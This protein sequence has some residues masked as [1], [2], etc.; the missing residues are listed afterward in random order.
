MH[1]V[2]I[3]ERDI[4]RVYF[5]GTYQE[6]W[7]ENYTLSIDYS[8]RK[9]VE[10]EFSAGLW[11]AVGGDE[12]LRE[13]LDSRDCPELTWQYFQAAATVWA[14]RRDCHR[15]GL[16]MDRLGEFFFSR[17]N[18]LVAPELMRAMMDEEGWSV[19]AAFRT[20]AFC[21]AD[22]TAG[23]V[24]MDQMF[25]L[26][27]RTGH[28]ISIMRMM[29]QRT[30]AA[31]YDS[32]QE[33]YRAPAGAL[34]CGETVRLS[35]RLLSG[36]AAG[37]ELLLYGDGLDLRLPMEREGDRFSVSFRAP[38]KPI[39][40]WFC[41]EIEYG[42]GRCWLCA[43][44]SGFIG[45]IYNSRA[46]G[47]RLTVYREDFETPA[48]FRRSVMYQIFP[49][50]FAFSQDG[51]AERGIEYHRQLG[52][53]PELHRSL[54][55]PVRSKPRPFEAAY[56]PDDFYGGTLKGIAE[57]LPY[58]KKLGVSC[59]YL[60]PIVEARSNHRYDASDYRK[61]DPILGTNRDLTALCRKAERLGIRVI[62]D[63]VFSHTGADSRYFNRYGNY[64]G[65]GACQGT[66]SKYYPWYQFDRFPDKYK[67]WWGFQDLPEVD[68]RN[69]QWQ[70]FVV[71]GPDSV[72]KYW[73]RQ[74]AAGWRLD[75]AD[76][77]PDDVLALIRQAAREEKPDALIL[78]EVWEDPVIKTGME[79]RRNYALG[80]S[81][82]SVMNYPIRDGLLD[83]IHGRRD[84]YGLRDL[85]IS[86]Q[87]NYPQPL[88]YSLMNLF[89]SHDTDRLRTALATPVYLRGKSREEQLAVKISRED[90]DKALEREKLAAALQFSL[91]GVPSIYY[92][93]EQGMT[94]VGD[95]FC[96]GPF[97]EDPE[98]A[99]LHDRYAELAALRNAVPALSTGEAVFMAASS[100]VL[101]IL[102]YI[103][104]GKDVFGL[105]AEDG[106][107]LTVLNR[108]EQ[109]LPFEANCA[110]AGKGVVRGT[111][112]PLSGEI[113][114]L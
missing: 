96:R 40:L 15:R 77:L 37:A 14:A 7:S 53:T 4:C 92:G 67:C 32:R 34:R 103:R 39:A 22:L 83:F 65:K 86:Q 3:E 33:E 89:G 84:A 36:E 76:E 91:P 72:V 82:D 93:D 79:G 46:N 108:S 106:A 2:K 31:A 110:A 73:L 23:S 16:S 68:E 25:P 97:R 50:R 44:D 98:A 78:G 59:L 94:G 30:L 24:E 20:A 6:R 104:G 18:P 101:L 60:N 51:T 45:R 71:T 10:A 64:P 27:P 63:G 62:L 52:Q 28:V 66:R 57:K 13:L 69:R 49:D 43:D 26:Q 75:V 109:A 19:D 105:P 100:E 56:S 9:W 95:P 58:L 114:E 99:S 38:E 11:R 5:G 12:E 112:A 70:D 80:W 35:F 21:C 74:G 47:F 81:L 61:V 85:L 111:A 90:L 102:R 8:E 55:E 54:A 88:Y 113:L 107:T 29:R 42:E 41:F 48:W 1:A 17:G 87:M